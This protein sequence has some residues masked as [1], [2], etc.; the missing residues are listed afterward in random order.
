[1]LNAALGSVILLTMSSG[2]QETPD[3]SIERVFGTHAL[4]T[5]SVAAG[6][7]HEEKFRIHG[8]VTRSLVGTAVRL[9]TWR[10][11]FSRA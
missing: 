10:P 2:R 7:S 3:G 4:E 1:M 11:I 6:C 9:G 8:C 5:S